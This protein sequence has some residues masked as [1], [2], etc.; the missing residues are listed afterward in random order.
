MSND[1]PE[2][3]KALRRNQER[4]QKPAAS[5]GAPAAGKAAPTPAERDAVRWAREVAGKEVRI[6]ASI[7]G[8]KCAL[9]VQPITPF[10]T[11]A[12]TLEGVASREA[13]TARI[14]SAIGAGEQVL[15]CYELTTGRPLA[16]S[17]EGGKIAFTAGKPRE[18]TQAMSPE[19]ML[20]KA[21]AQAEL[22]AKTRKAEPGRERGR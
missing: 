7:N 16:V 6:A 19:Q 3:I 8:A 17:T 11:P 1:E 22:L 21:K 2:Y 5:T 9:I 10:G 20:R 14:D 4:Q 13:L 15:G 12:S 18:R